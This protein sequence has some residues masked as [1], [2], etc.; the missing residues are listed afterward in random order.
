M[1]LSELINKHDLSRAY[2]AKK[3]NM[4]PGTFHNKLKGNN[5]SRFTGPELSA[6]LLVLLEIKNDLGN[7]YS[8]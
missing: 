5:G 8:V 6:L 3:I 4:L 7:F 1:T 2:L